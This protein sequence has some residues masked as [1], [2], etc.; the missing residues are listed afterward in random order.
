MP[1]DA[2]AR[3]D[4][5]ARR[6][7]ARARARYRWVWGTGIALAGVFGSAVLMRLAVLPTGVGLPGLPVA[8]AAFPATGLAVLG[9]VV[10]AALVGVALDRV[11]SP[12]GS[13]CWWGGATTV[14]WGYWG[15]LVWPAS[16]T[17]PAARLAPGPPPWLPWAVLVVALASSLVAVRALRAAVAEDRRVLALLESGRRSVGTVLDLE[18]IP[19]S[20][21]TGPARERLLL[22]IGFRDGSRAVVS[23]VRL[24]PRPGLAPRVGDR[25]DLWYRPAAVLVAPDP[26]EPARLDDRHLVVRARKPTV[27]F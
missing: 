2:A 17:E 27:D 18:A 26:Q 25:L 3:S 10:I 4:P 14:A 23:R 5:F 16:A 13:P 12:V 15:G 7:R 20:G 6:A 8:H 11:L 21:L 24:D 19:A 9:A 1:Y 22:H